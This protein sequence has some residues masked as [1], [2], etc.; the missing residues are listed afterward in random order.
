MFKVLLVP[1]VYGEPERCFEIVDVWGKI[2]FN[3][4]RKLTKSDQGCPRGGQNLS[5]GYPAEAPKT[6]SPSKRAP[7]PNNN[8]NG[9]E[10]ERQIAMLVVFVMFF[11]YS[12]ASFGMT[13]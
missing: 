13:C 7:V 9:S 5:K 8:A 2:A 6:R 12:S 1:F 10:I 4:A 3:S 11:L